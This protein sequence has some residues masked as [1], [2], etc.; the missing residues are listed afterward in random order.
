LQDGIDRVLRRFPRERRL[1]LDDAAAADAGRALAR[2]R[3]EGRPLGVID[4]QLI[5]IATSLRYVVATRD[6]DFLDRGVDLVN[7]WAE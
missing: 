6:R 3:R 5:G 4:A 7:P 2:A 1:V